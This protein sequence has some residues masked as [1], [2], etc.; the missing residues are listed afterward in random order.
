MS[1]HENFENEWGSIPFILTGSVSDHEGLLAQK[2]FD[3]RLNIGDEGAH[4]E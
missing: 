2:W 4:E 3:F 1:K